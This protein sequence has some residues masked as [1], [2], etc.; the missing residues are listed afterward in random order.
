MADGSYC[1]PCQYVAVSDAGVGTT[2]NC[3]MNTTSLFYALSRALQSND[4]SLDALQRPVVLI[5]QAEAVPLQT[6]LFTVVTLP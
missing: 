2:L 6:W 3:D 4:G 5:H 1:K